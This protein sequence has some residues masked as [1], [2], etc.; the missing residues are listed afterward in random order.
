[1]VTVSILNQ[2]GIREGEIV[3]ELPIEEIRERVSAGEAFVIKNIFPEQE[4]RHMV[5]EVFDLY[6]DTEPR[7]LDFRWDQESFW[8][9]DD[10]PPHSNV[11]KVQA[12][13]FAFI[14][15]KQLERMKN[16][17]AMLGRLRN[18]IAGLPIEYGFRPKDDHLVIPA[19]QHYPCG[20]GYMASHEDP[21]VPDKCVISLFL[22]KRGVDY[23]SGGLFVE[24]GGEILD[25]EHY[26]EPGDLFIFRP[27]IPHGV[28]AVD[29]DSARNFDTLEGRWRMAAVLTPSTM[30]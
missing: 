17:A 6:K 18:R 8:R 13:Y 20:G 27:N 21:I 16:V 25:I 5:R 19:L 26:F 24:E 23:R 11:P 22:S 7:V 4:M 10:N 15:N 30:G 2:S 28:A 3:L 12:V 29:S 1:M 14:W 9:I